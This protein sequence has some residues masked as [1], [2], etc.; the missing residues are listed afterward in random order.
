MRKFVRNYDFRR[1]EAK[2]VSF[3][4]NIEDADRK[5]AIEVLNNVFLS[6]LKCLADNFFKVWCVFKYIY[7]DHANCTIN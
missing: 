7:K 2:S 6:N 5:V 4:R 1:T 3:L